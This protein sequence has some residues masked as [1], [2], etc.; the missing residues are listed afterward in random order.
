MLHSHL[1]RVHSSLCSNFYSLGKKTISYVC[2]YVVIRHLF[3]NILY[4]VDIAGETFWSLIGC[5]K[6][7]WGRV[8]E[9]VGIL[10]Q[11]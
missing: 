10:C 8:G 3:H 9:R 6:G 11:V 2:F 7:L 4:L 1:E 5:E